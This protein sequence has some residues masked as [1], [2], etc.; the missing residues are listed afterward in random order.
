VWRSGGG[1]AT[2]ARVAVIERYQFP[3]AVADRF[4]REHPEVHPEDTALVEAAARQWF[5]LIAREPKRTLALPSRAVSDWWLAFLH[6]EDA[7]RQFCQDGLGGFL[8]HR[9]PPSGAGEGVADGPG[10]TRTLET[11]RRDEPDAPHRLPWLFRVDAK[12][13]ILNARRY[14]ATCGG[15][16]ECH[17]VAGC[18]CLHHL[19]GLERAL[20]RTHDP[21]RDKPAARPDWPG[22]GA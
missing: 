2:A 9:P 3:E 15:G 17:S 18:V 13:Q 19:A 10:L 1:R 12:V 4:R 20:R 21:G 5:R 8:P 16:P 6:V 7:Y 14:I 11:A 22:W